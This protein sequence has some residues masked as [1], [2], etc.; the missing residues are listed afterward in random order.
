[1]R[2]AAK[3]RIPPLL[4]KPTKYPEVGFRPKASIRPTLSMLQRSPPK[5]TFIYLAEFW[6]AK[7]GYADKPDLCMSVYC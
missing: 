6:S 7:V 5:R 2:T 1:M 4:T 3:V